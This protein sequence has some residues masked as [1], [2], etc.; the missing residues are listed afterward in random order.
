MQLRTFKNTTPGKW[1]SRGLIAVG[2]IAMCVC[3]YFQ[4]RHGW[5]LGVILA[6]KIALATL[7]GLVDIATALLVSAGAIFFA[8]YFYK[9]GFA[10]CFFALI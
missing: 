6:D 4:A 9:M 8:W 1:V 5:N 2:I 10:A 7:H 3:V